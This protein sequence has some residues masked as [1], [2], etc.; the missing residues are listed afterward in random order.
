MKTPTSPAAL[1]VARALTELPL[2][3]VAEIV[4]IQRRAI[5]AVEAGVSVFNDHNVRLI[6]FYESKGIEFLGELTFGKNVA[7]AGARWRSPGDLDTVDLGKYRVVNSG[8][9]FQAARALLGLKQTQIAE[10]A[11][12]K[13]SAIGRV[14]AGE[15]WPS[16]IDKLREFY[17]KSGV[18]F[19]GWSDAHTQLHYGVGARWAV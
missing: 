17:I 4:L 16:I 14:E 8:V 12:L 15:P 19:L 10:R 18:E 3:E 11:G 6:E 5:A 13:S 2:S 7:R 9:Y 1:R